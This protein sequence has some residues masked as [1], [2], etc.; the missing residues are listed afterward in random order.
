MN[1]DLWHVPASLSHNW[2]T[3]EICEGESGPL[4]GSRQS[5]QLSTQPPWAWEREGREGHCVHRASVN[6]CTQRLS[7]S[8][9]ISCSLQAKL[10]STDTGVRCHWEVFP[11]H[12]VESRWWIHTWYRLIHTSSTHLIHRTGKTHPLW[13]PTIWLLQPSVVCECSN[14]KHP[15]PKCTQLRQQSETDTPTSK[16]SPLPSSYCHVINKFILE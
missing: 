7:S 5:Q 10:S 4:W 3:F 11:A 16:H 2:H 13:F 9:C 12:L 6:T 1:R 14:N 8:M 15:H